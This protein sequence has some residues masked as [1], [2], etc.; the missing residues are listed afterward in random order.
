MMYL[1][2]IRGD[3]CPESSAG[4][5]GSSGWEGERR[6]GEVGSGVKTRQKQVSEN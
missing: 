3:N 6:G 5:G 1:W 2:L 4:G